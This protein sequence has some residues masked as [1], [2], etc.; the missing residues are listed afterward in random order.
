MSLEKS[1]KLRNVEIS[2]LIPI[3]IDFSQL[4]PDLSRLQ[5]PRPRPDLI[6]TMS[7][8]SRFCPDGQDKNAPWS[9]SRPDFCRDFIPPQDIL[10]IVDLSAKTMH[11]FILSDRSS[12]FCPKAGLF[13]APLLKWNFCWVRRRHW[14]NFRT[15]G[16]LEKKFRMY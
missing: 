3:Y 2:W 8:R 5:S 4:Y 10:P 1:R 14:T 15:A 16:Y 6:F 12:I 13:K 11:S 9:L 7:S